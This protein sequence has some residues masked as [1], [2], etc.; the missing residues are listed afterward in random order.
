M[1]EEGQKGKTITS[2]ANSL[3]AS[4]GPPLDT[5]ISTDSLS[6]LQVATA[7]DVDTAM[8]VCWFFA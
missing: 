3:I 2:A 5:V 8:E 4:E 6:T 7:P 1:D